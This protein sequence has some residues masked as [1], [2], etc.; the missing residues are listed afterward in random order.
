MKE[1]ETREANIE[2]DKDDVGREEEIERR[3]KEKTVGI[4]K[5]MTKKMTK[6]EKDEK[7]EEEN[8]SPCTACPDFYLTEKIILESYERH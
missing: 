1:E 3:G 6:K 5:N 8:N 4:M 2:D 7:K